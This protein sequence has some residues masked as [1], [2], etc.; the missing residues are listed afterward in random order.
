MS[1]AEKL[2][3]FIHLPKC[4]GTSVD[5]NL[6]SHF[7]K[8]F[9]QYVD[10]KDNPKLENYSQSGFDGVDVMSIHNGRFNYAR[11][12]KNVP[13]TYYAVCR[14][15]IAAAVSMFNFA[16]TAP[17]TQNYERVKDLEFWQFMAFS[18]QIPIWAP[19]FQSYYLCGARNWDAVKARIADL[20]L[21]LAPLSALNQT[22]RRMTGREMQPEL[23]RNKST[24]R[25]TVSDLD[26]REISML[27]EMF[28]VDMQLWDYT[29]DIYEKQR[30]TEHQL[31][32]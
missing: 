22:Y 2:R 30:D 9:F 20:R 29:Q 15:P 24:K 31:G 23:D 4:G 16:T 10:R 25:L 27:R 21:H 13:S 8:R 32:L 1:G 26:A 17:H 11:S 12:F 3:V 5:A 14:D 19:N 28:N 6:Q 7:G 18:Y